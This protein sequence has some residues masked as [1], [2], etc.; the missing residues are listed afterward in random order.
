MDLVNQN[1]FKNI[2]IILLI[3]VNIISLS[4]IWIQNSENRGEV[5]DGEKQGK[6]ESVSLMKEVLKLNEDQTKQLEK[7]RTDRLEQSRLFND[8]LSMLKRELAE[9]LFKSKANQD[10][11]NEKTKMIGELQ[12]K[13]E[14][15]R[16]SHFNELLA[17]CTPEQKEKL[18]PIIEELFG[19][20]PPKEELIR[21]RP[22]NEDRKPSEIRKEMENKQVPPS[23]EEKVEKY[24]QRL[25]LSPDQVEKL[26]KIFLDIQ[27]KAELNKVNK[28]MNPEE[29][30]KEKERLRTEED[31]LVKEILS[32]EQKYEFEKMQVKRRK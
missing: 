21:K 29:F 24:S 26:R 14:L 16:Y 23:L 4:I 5:P 8:S 10:L 22:V 12:S 25:N 9:E 31:Q 11:V 17:I 13:I 7:L 6:P 27:N 3:I 32:D 2:L 18:K 15:V 28:K 1:K 19:R 20:K 30:E